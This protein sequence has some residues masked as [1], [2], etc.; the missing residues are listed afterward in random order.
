MVGLTSRHMGDRQ[1]TQS[2]MQ[3]IDDG[4]S[5]P[6]AWRHGI[7]SRGCPWLAVTG[8]RDRPNLFVSAQRA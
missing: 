1:A 3:A 6:H 2:P 8:A 5:R 4:G 7:P